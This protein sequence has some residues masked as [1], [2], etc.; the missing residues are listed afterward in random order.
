MPKQVPPTLHGDETG[1][2]KEVAYGEDGVGKVKTVFGI[3]KRELGVE[4]LCVFGVNNVA[5]ATR[6]SSLLLWDGTNLK[7]VVQ[8]V[9]GGRIRGI[10]GFEDRL[11]TCGETVSSFSPSQKMQLTNQLLFV[12]RA[13]L[14]F[15]RGLLVN[16][17]QVFKWICL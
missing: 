12:A 14:R 7:S 1:L 4:K 6:S 11:V 8:S 5:V 17:L 3:Q 10:G 16:S 2:I 13:R 15:D 9:G